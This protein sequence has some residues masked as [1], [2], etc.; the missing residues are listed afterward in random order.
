MGEVTAVAVEKHPPQPR[1]EM[2]LAYLATTTAA[3]ECSSAK[4][5]S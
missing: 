1:E 4:A 3:R 2:A 5:E